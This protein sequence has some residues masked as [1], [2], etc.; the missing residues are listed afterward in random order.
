MLTP[1]VRFV[2]HSID[3]TNVFRSIW[4]RNTFMSDKRSFLELWKG[5]GTLRYILMVVGVVSNVKK[6][7][8]FKGK[9]LVNLKWMVGGVY[10]KCAPFDVTTYS[11]LSKQTTNRL[12]F[13]LLRNY[14]LPT[15]R[16]K[17]WFEGAMSGKC[18]VRYHMSILFF[19]VALTTTSVWPGALS[20]HKITFLCVWVHSGRFVINA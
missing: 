17:W 10:W 6:C 1:F 15:D 2:I 13:S 7:R 18:G 12:I 5:P 16:Y 3:K 4:S 11:H 9:I 20:C 14:V 19:Y 8:F